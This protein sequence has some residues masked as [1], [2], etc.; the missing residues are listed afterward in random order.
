MKEDKIETFAALE[1]ALTNLQNLSQE[2]NTTFNESAAIY[3]GQGEAW[4]SANSTTESNKMVNYA[5]EAIKIAKNVSEVSAAINKFKT[6]SRNID[7]A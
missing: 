1:T 5:D 7:E 4:Y 6:T 3:E 2:I